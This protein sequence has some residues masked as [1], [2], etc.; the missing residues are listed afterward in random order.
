MTSNSRARRSVRLIVAMAALA[1]LLPS[2]AAR[3]DDTPSAAP[4]PPVAAPRAPAARPMTTQTKQDKAATAPRERVKI[5]NVSAQAVP[6]VHPMIEQF[7]S[8][9]A[10][11]ALREPVVV[12]VQVA[13]PFT[14][15][16]R[17][18]SPVIVV[19]GQPIKDSVVPFREPDRVIAVLPDGGRFDQPLSVQV[20]WQGDLQ[21]TLSE[22]VQA[23]VAR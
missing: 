22:P 10:K 23:Q 6:P 1:A 17:S 7:A 11:A 5:S 3:A 12:S 8:E 15:L 19:N 20:G 13:T 4:R 2:G 18:A 9:S 21:R 14:G 16:A